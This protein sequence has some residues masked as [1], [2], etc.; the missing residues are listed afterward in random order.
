[1]AG[2]V[3]ATGKEAIERAEEGAGSHTKPR[4]QTDGH[5]P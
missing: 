5:D 3:I 1:M 4:D 2:D